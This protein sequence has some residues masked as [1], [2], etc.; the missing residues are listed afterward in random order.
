[1]C[2]FVVDGTWSRNLNSNL[3]GAD[4]SGRAVGYKNEF[5]RSNSRRFYDESAYPLAQKFYFG[6]PMFGAT[7][8]DARQIFARLMETIKTEI[9]SGRCTELSFVGWSRGAA[10]VS[11]AVQ[12]LAHQRYFHGYQSKIRATR[13]GHRVQA[14]PVEPAIELPR[15]KFVGLFDSVAMIA[16]GFRATAND[17]DWGDFIPQQVDYFVHIVA[18][19]RTGPIKNVVD[20]VPRA[21]SV[22]A[23][24]AVTIPMGL[25]THDQVG[26]LANQPSAQIAYQIMKSHALRAEVL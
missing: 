24:R 8:A 9:V 11:E 19:D 25:S 7:G 14:V 1:M 16:D 6:G 17:P 3:F 26:G 12:H 21:P 4:A 5:I 18:G 20:F 22:N 10:I 23:K 13:R 2:L 15:I